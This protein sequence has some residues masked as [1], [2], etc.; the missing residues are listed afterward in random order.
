MRDG[1]TIS[2]VCAGLALS[3]VKDTEEAMVEAGPPLTATEWQSKK[4]D[5]S[6]QNTKKAEVMVLASLKKEKTRGFGKLQKG[7]QE[8]D[9]QSNFPQVGHLFLR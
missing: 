1:V 7:N 8:E 2:D 5:Y 4:W 9:T 6:D 3:A